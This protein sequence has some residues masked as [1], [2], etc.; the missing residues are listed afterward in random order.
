MGSTMAAAVV[1]SAGSLAHPLAPQCGY[2]DC[3]AFC[4]GECPLRPNISKP[5]TEDLTV[6]RMTPYNVSGI[7]QHDTG[8]AAG[9]MGFLLAKFLRDSRCSPPYDTHECFLDDHTIVGAFNVSFDSQYGPYLKCN[10]TSFTPGGE[11]LNMSDWTCAY[12]YPGADVWKVTIPGAM[13]PPPCNRAN[14]SVGKDPTLHRFWFPE[15]SLISAFGGYWYDTPAR[16]ECLAGHVPGD[17]SGCTWA[18][19][20]TPKYINATC[21]VTG[22]FKRVE[23]SSPACFQRCPPNVPP[24]DPCYVDCFEA[25]IRY[26]NTTTAMLVQEWEAAFVRCPSLQPV[27]PQL[28]TLARP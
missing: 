26:G 22:L 1:L 11:Y 18:V 12:G 6:Y 28:H 15:W 7:L 10:P 19:R 4:S 8:D 21:L 20:E 27:P 24:S 16:G 13:C 17:G 23:A 3:A 25:A 5:G 9:D 2:E 14:I